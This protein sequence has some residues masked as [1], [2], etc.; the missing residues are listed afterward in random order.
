MD[1]SLVFRLGTM[2]ADVVA[3]AGYRGFRRGKV[4]VVP[5]LR[6][7]LGA[8]AVRFAPRSLVRKLVKG[9]QGQEPKTVPPRGTDRR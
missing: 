1:K 8:F 3:R 6:N 4:I 7:K 9:L 2:A 5:G